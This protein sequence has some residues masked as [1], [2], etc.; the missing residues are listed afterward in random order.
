MTGWKSR[1]KVIW[2][3]G[4]ELVCR[5]DGLP[6]FFMGFLLLAVTFVPYLILGEGSIFEIHDQLDETLL[7]YVLN[8]RHWGEN[9]AVFPEMLGGV[10]VSGMQPAAVLFVPLYLFLPAFTAFL[11]QYAVCFLAGFGGMYGSVRKLT[12]SS[13]LAVVSAGCFCLLPL[14]PIYGLSVLGVPLALYAYLCLLRGQQA[15]EASQRGGR[16]TG[17]IQIWFALLLLVFLGLTSH[18]VLIGYVILTF[19]GIALA[20]RIVGRRGA[21]RWLIVGFLVLTGVYAAVNY[22]LFAELLLGRAGYVSHREELINAALPFWKTVGE[23]FV[24]SAQHAKSLHQYLIVPILVLLAAEGCRYARM[25][26]E[27][28]SAYRLAVAGLAALAAVAVMY[29]VC[30]SEPV[31]A[32]KNGQQGFFRYF[33]MERYYWVYPAGWYLEFACAFGLWWR[34][35]GKWQSGICKL[36]ALGLVLLPTLQ[37]IKYQ[38]YFYHNVNQINNGSEITG[39][40]SYENYYAEDLMKQLEEAIG[41]DMSTYRVAHLAVSPAP[42]LMHGFYTVDG[43]SNNYSLEY[44]HRFRK[45]IEKELEK[46]PETAVYF[47]AWGSRCY[48]FNSITGTYWELEKGNNIRFENLEFDM[49]ALRE[50]G[51]EY[52]FSGGEILQPESLGLEYMGYFET[53]KSLWGIWLYRL[54]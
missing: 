45:V 5:I 14:Q 28:R 15:G 19:W 48:L 29:G 11:V 32:W 47:D 20:V 37:E 51:C 25:D 12:G 13:I 43:Y 21:N 40:V 23:V 6:L 34:Q 36:L 38:S 9:T 3:K 8:A 26:R 1:A 35:K 16:Q 33:Q 49:T 7:T 50:L 54:K 27:E 31:T 46:S 18:L 2:K 22:R 42:A 39:Y 17:R 41:R 10:N 52:L 53:E 4:E 30:K 44:K 24:N